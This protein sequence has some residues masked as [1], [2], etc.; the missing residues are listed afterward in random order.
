MDMEVAQLGLSEDK[1]NE[2]LSE[3]NS[4]TWVQ[5]KD[6]SLQLPLKAVFSIIVVLTPPLSLLSLSLWSLSFSLTN[7]KKKKL[8]ARNFYLLFK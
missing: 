1:T 4:D 3:N 5:H 6:E 8:N 2:T 7:Q